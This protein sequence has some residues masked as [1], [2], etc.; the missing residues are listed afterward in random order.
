MTI[1]RAGKHLP[2]PGEACPAH[3]D[4]SGR[5]PSPGWPNLQPKPGRSGGGNVGH[6]SWRTVMHFHVHWNR[7][8]VIA[9]ST[10][11]GGR[12]V[13]DEN[14]ASPGCHC[15]EPPCDA[16]ICNL[17]YCGSDCRVAKQ[18]L[19]MTGRG[20][21]GRNARGSIFLL[22]ALATRQSA[23]ARTVDQIAASQSSSSQ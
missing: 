1:S 11:A 2:F 16:P 20:D 9:R 23:T 8:V 7:T 17:T 12:P 15:E 5:D 19:A 10:P 21:T 6:R 18:L 3:N 4:R 22:G 14:R 13:M